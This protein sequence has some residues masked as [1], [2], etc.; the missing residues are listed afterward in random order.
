MKTRGNVLAPRRCGSGG[1]GTLC[2]TSWPGELS[3]KRWHYTK[4][5]LLRRN[6]PHEDPGDECAGQRG[7][8]VLRWG[9]LS[10][11]GNNPE[12]QS[13]CSRGSKA[14]RWQDMGPR[15]VS[16]PDVSDLEAQGKELG[17]FQCVREVITVE[18]GGGQHLSEVF[19]R[20]VRGTY[21]GGIQGTR[22]DVGNWLGAR[23]VVQA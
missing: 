15:R 2:E 17:S 8:R 18:N 3:L 22:E 12:G 6:K 4:C 13:G 5:R 11:S 23:T 20:S 21:R 7:R 10:C 9:N 14:G 19:K 16:E 1:R